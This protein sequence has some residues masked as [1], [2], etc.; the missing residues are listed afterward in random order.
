MSRREPYEGQAMWIIVFGLLT[1]AAA[2]FLGAGLWALAIFGIFMAGS[3]LYPAFMEWG[4]N[5]TKSKLIIHGLGVYSCL[6][7]DP[8]A[9]TADSKEAPGKFLFAGGGGGPIFGFAWTDGGH[10]Y[11]NGIYISVPRDLAI[12]VPGVGWYLPVNPV[13]L[14][15]SNPLG[16]YNK[17][18]QASIKEHGFHPANTQFFDADYGV[19]SLSAPSETNLD[20]HALDVS[21]RKVLSEHRDM[22]DDMQGKF[23]TDL[24]LTAQMVGSVMPK[25]KKHFFEREKKEEPEGTDQSND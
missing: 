24:D 5:R 10:S 2:F 23:A 12:R 18:F 4:K 13:A 3:Q 11:V 20:R 22:T 1:A 19:V 16:Q 14:T 25:Q 8:V 21:R 9:E 6:D 15:S 7:P 17:H